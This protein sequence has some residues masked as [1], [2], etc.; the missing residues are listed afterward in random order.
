MIA[1]V[2]QKKKLLLKRESLAKEQFGRLSLLET[3]R[4]K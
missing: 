3:D 2:C 1:V 4:E